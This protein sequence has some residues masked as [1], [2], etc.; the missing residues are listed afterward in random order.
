MSKFTELIKSPHIKIAAATGVS[1]IILA[2]FS[3][4]ILNQPLS[5][6]ELAVAPFVAFIYE[7][8]LNKHNGSNL[9]KPLYWV[10]GIFLITF[11]LIILNLL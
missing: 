11:I 10:I 6:L 2:Y 3:K 9:L 1:I 4:R 7:L 8:L 5:N